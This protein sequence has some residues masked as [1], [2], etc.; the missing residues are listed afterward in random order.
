MSIP[1]TP[2][3]VRQWGLVE[4]WPRESFSQRMMQGEITRVEVG[5]GVSTDE[6]LFNSDFDFLCF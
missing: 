2:V 1:E 5:I 4:I 6:E 3:S